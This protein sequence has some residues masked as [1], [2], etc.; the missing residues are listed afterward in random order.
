[1]DSGMFLGLQEGAVAALE[2]GKEWFE[3]LNNAYSRR[4][5]L[6]WQLVDQL[7]ASYQ[8]NTSGM[9]VWAKLPTNEDVKT[10]VDRLLQEKRIFIAPGD[11]FGTNGSGYIRFSLCVKE[12]AIQEALSRLTN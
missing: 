8:K 1:M 11:I 4:R 9:F 5:E 7:G 12:E 6:V 10:Y 3:Q 2:L